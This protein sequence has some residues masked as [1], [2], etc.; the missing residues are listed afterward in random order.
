MLFKLQRKVEGIKKNY[1]LRPQIN[2]SST[3]D[4]RLTYKMQKNVK[5]FEFCGVVVAFTLRL[6][7][8]ENK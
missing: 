5:I 1:L 4:L 8:N 7:G 2:K 6:L 3:M